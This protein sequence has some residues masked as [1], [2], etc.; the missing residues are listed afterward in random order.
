MLK[1]YS[2]SLTNIINR[3]VTANSVND[4]QTN[5]L[6]IMELKKIL[7]VAHSDDIY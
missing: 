6:Y 7:I 5:H 4:G 3:F 2:H 1:P